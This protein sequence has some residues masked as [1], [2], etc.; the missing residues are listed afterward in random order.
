MLTD[1]RWETKEQHKR[2]KALVAAAVVDTATIPGADS[3][4]AV[5]VNGTKVGRIYKSPV[6]K[7]KWIAAHGYFSK[8]E[9][10][11]AT[12]KQ[13][14]KEIVLS[15]MAARVT[16][17]MPFDNFL[18]DCLEL[19][20]LLGCGNDYESRCAKVACVIPPDD[21]TIR[22]Y[23][24][25]MVLIVESLD[26]HALLIKRLENSNPVIC[27]SAS[28]DLYRA[29]GEW[30]YL[31]DHV[32]K[33]L[34]QSKEIERKFLVDVGTLPL[35]ESSVK[36]TQGYIAEQPVVRVRYEG[37]QH[38]PTR[39][40]ITFKGGG[41][42]TRTE[43]EFEVPEAD[44]QKAVTLLHSMSQTG[45]LQK[46]RYFHEVLESDGTRRE[47]TVDQFLSPLTVAGLWMAE[48]ELPTEDTKFKKPGWV[49]K[50]V[51]SDPQYTNAKLVKNGRPK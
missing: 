18:T 44:R 41:L 37:E 43:Q 10:S 30:S 3:G 36:L 2:I 24:D 48:V 9:K 31:K 1:E 39:A 46:I 49:T 29:H 32:A 4:Q 35:A 8:A 6:D 5:L 40:W 14:I 19:S 21:Q 47:W 34:S 50:E 33:V 42:L 12:P 28:G 7:G 23:K 13:A 16:G 27:R 15:H 38:A 17:R 45:I 11:V 20:K 22:V 26:S 25:N 51:T